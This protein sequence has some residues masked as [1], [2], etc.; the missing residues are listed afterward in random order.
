LVVLTE[1]Q[2]R[3]QYLFEHLADLLAAIDS[4]IRNPALVA[5]LLAPKFHAVVRHLPRALARAD[6]STRDVCMLLTELQGPLHWRQNGSYTDPKL[7]DGYAYCE[8]LG[9]G[10]HWRNADVAL[11]L[12][13]LGP[14]VTYPEH[15][16]PATE[17]Y[18]VLSGDADW[19]RG[20]TPWQSHPPGTVIRH[21]SMEPHA[22]RTHAEPLL[23]AYLWHDHLHEPARLIS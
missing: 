19:R 18:V 9:P 1:Q 2:R 17:T 15:V 12:L 7:L 14:E 22:M 21:E 10:G 13:L 5:G 11:G 3:W 8:L 6:A 23:A 4:R 20:L 16:H